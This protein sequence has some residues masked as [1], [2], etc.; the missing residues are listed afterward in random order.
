[1][2]PNSMTHTLSSLCP[3]GIHE[4]LVARSGSIGAS[5]DLQPLATPSADLCT[6]LHA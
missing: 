4:G 6:S 2:R 1:L 5:L 3:D